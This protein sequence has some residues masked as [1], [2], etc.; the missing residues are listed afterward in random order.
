[1]KDKQV[2]RGAQIKNDLNYVNLIGLYSRYKRDGRDAKTL[3]F[4][5][6]MVRIYDGSLEYDAHVLRGG[7]I[8]SV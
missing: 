1:M 3:L 2:H 7:V 6:C 5:T 4:L 8:Q